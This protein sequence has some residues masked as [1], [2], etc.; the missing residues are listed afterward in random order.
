MN[1][2]W[3]RSQHPLHLEDLRKSGLSDETITEAGIKSVPPREIHQRLGFDIL[4]LQSMYEIPYGGEYARFRVFYEENAKYFKDGKEKP[5]YLT[6]KDSGNR[7]YIPPKARPILNDLSIPLYITE[8]EK[9]SLKATQE[10]LPCIA[11]SGLWN[12]KIKDKDALISD[13]DLIDL[14]GRTINIVP[15]TDWLE[16]NRK[17]EQKNLKQAVYRLAYSLIDKGAKVSWVELP[18]EDYETR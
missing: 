5:K 17:G 10:G 13:F 2:N 4:G 18:G 16:P 8:G 12:W 1:E 7:L 11:I 15:D 14:E 9:K 6:G 3:I